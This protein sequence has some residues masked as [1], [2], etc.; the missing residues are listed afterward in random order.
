MSLSLNSTEEI[1]AS[2]IYLTQ[3]NAITNIL[4]LISNSS[5]GVASNTYTKLQIDSFLNL[6]RNLID[7]Y[8]L[9]ETNNLL[10]N[11]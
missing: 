7:S 1:I 3:G 5:D 9:V 2:S 6:K 10:N 8:S 4:D 11:K